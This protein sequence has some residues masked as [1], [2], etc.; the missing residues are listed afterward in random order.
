MVVLVK[1]GDGLAK[2]D[3]GTSTLKKATLTLAVKV[4]AGSV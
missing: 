1:V 2:Q 3:A 4:N